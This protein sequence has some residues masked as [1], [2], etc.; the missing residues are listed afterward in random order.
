[1]VLLAASGCGNERA[2]PA[3]IE[4]TRDS[5]RKTVRYPAVGLTLEV[6]RRAIVADRPRPGV[7]RI[8]LGQPLVAS[9]AYKRK[10]PLPKSRKDLRTARRRLVK[11][12]EKRAKRFEVR[13]SEVTKAA[14]TNAIEVVGDQTIARGRLRTRS[15]HVFKGKMEYVFELLAPVKKF[16]ST[17]RAVFQPMI[18]SL[19][20]TG[21]LGRRAKRSR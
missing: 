18:G 5:P 14:G 9:F 13:S 4:F 15:I 21:K 20:V 10:E 8:V 16:A 19:E 11:A 1:M 17:D 6:P 3:E 7:F 2:R 12:I